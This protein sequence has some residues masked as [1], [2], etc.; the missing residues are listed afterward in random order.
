MDRPLRTIETEET[1]ALGVAMLG[2]V[3]AEIHADLAA[4]THAMVQTGADEEPDPALVAA[5]ARG[6][7]LF[8]AL[9]DALIPLWRHRARLLEGGA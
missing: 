7:P 9:G 3:A 4:A 1:G 8:D 6:A 5:Y 2:A